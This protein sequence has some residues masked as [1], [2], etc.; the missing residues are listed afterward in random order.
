[1][2]AFIEDAD[3]ALGFLSGSI[4]PP[5]QLA[6][7]FIDINAYSLLVSRDY[8]VLMTVLFFFFFVYETF[9][10][11][12]K[13]AFLFY[14]LEFVRD[15]FLSLFPLRRKRSRIFLFLLHVARFCKRSRVPQFLLHLVRLLLNVAELVVRT[16]RQ[17]VHDF[18]LF[19]PDRRRRMH[20]QHVSRSS[21]RAPVWKGLVANERRCC[22]CISKEARVLL[23]PC[24]HMCLCK[25]CFGV[26][27]D[28]DQ[29]RCPVCRAKIEHHI[30]VF[31]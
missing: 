31:L 28:A 13:Y 2:T 3:K 18:E 14:C 30:N 12:F 21:P 17:I 25:T 8:A 29:P 15:A 26:V 9:A 5:L 16:V 24:S 10:A 27:M 19:A 11:C 4:P 1:M 23:R 7:V 20:P 6:M 22:V